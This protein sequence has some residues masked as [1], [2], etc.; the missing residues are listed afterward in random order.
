M[1]EGGVGRERARKPARLF[2]GQQLIDATV[3]ADEYAEVL[4][5]AGVGGKEVGVAAQEC[6][7][8]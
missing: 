5:V 2:P 3:D 4:V 8:G 7:P 6:R 1:H